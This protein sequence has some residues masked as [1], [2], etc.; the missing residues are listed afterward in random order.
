MIALVFNEKMFDPNLIRFA[1][2][3]RD[4]QFSFPER[5]VIFRAGKSGEIFLCTLPEV[6]E[7][8]E[9]PTIAILF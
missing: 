2:N 9:F 3:S 8:D 7:M 6:F 5:N 1:K 4:V